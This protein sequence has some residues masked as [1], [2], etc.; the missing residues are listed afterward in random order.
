MHIDVH[1]ANNYIYWV[2]FDKLFF[3]GIF[4]I[5]TDGTGQQGI[6]TDGIGT[7]GIRGLA[8]DW[9]AGELIFFNIK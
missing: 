6:I 9:I 3:N 5:K 7:N 2:D 4:R 1:V 8:I